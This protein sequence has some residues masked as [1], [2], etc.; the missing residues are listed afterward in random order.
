LVCQSY[1][2]DAMISKINVLKYKYCTIPMFQIL[3]STGNNNVNSIS[4]K[5]KNIHNIVKFMLICM[6]MS[7]SAL[8]PHSQKC[9]LLFWFLIL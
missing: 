3:N 2:N 4:Y 7:E 9:L 6:F 8:K 1:S 5:I